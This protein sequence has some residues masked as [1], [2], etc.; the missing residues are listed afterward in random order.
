MGNCL[1]FHD[2]SCGVCIKRCPVGAITPAGHDKDKCQQYVYNELRF[3]A[4]EKYGVMETGCGLCQTRVPCESAS[5][6][7]LPEIGEY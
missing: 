2:G 6:L 3:S 4:G 5:P 7:S 1:Y